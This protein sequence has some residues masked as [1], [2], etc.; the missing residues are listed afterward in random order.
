MF[1]LCLRG[2]FLRPSKDGLLRSIGD[3]VLLADVSV[4]VRLSLNVCPVMDLLPRCPGCYPD[5]HQ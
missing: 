2:G 5:S 1:S 4:N 3:P